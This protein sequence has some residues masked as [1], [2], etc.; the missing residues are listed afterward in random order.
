MSTRSSRVHL[1]EAPAKCKQACLRRARRS[2]IGQAGSSG[3][4]GWQPRRKPAL[5]QA[6]IGKGTRSRPGTCAWRRNAGGFGLRIAVA[7]QERKPDAGASAGDETLMRQ[8]Q[9]TN[10]KIGR[11]GSDIGRQVCPETSEADGSPEGSQGTRYPR[12]GESGV[13]SNVGPICISGRPAPAPRHLAG[14]VQFGR[15]VPSRADRTAQIS[16]TLA[17]LYQHFIAILGQ[18]VPC[19]KL[20]GGETRT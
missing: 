6:R 20:R 14:C 4:I 16:Q 9:D 8:S 15:I 12:A 13:G 1:E 11:A 19:L 2:F 5:P 7:G 17:R 18:F 10:R 3:R